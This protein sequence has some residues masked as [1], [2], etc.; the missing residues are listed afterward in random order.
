MD[1]LPEIEPKSQDELLRMTYK[2]LES[3][4]TE[5]ERVKVLNYIEK[6]K[7]KIEEND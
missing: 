7:K 6:L 5:E 3:A 4:P 1:N 2:A